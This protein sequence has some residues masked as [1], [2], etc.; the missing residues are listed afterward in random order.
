MLIANTYVGR[1]PTSDGSKLALRKF[2]AVGTTYVAQLLR[3]GSQISLP[4]RLNY[5]KGQEGPQAWLHDNRTLL[6]ASNR[7]GHW[8][9]LKQGI[10]ERGA[11]PLVAE[12]NSTGR[13]TVTSDGRWILYMV[14]PRSLDA[15]FYAGPVRLMRVSATGGT[16]VEVTR[17][18]NSDEL[19][20]PRRAGS[21]CVLIRKSDAGTGIVLRSFDPFN[22]IG[23][24]IM[25]YPIKPTDQYMFALSES[26][27]RVAITT[28]GTP[29]IKILSL[30]SGA[31]DVVTAGSANDWNTIAWMPGDRGFVVSLATPTGMML[32]DIDL[33]GRTHILWDERGATRT[34]GVPSYDGRLLAILNWTDD[35]NIWTVQGF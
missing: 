9:I 18:R 35:S 6:L 17:L 24:E 31:V 21:N 11:Q 16:P 22:G 5:S 29:Q 20:C 4:I 28:K 2:S 26:G 19:Q 27:T 23:P 12:A 3:G 13:P 7:T 34:W 1:G 25:S 14:G 10:G 15:A 8:E 33:T 30:V 32:L